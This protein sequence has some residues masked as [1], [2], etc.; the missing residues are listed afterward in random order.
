MQVAMP[1]T[2][3]RIIGQIVVK[4]PALASV[5]WYKVSCLVRVLYNNV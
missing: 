1:Q 5:L 3:W 2:F 4:Q